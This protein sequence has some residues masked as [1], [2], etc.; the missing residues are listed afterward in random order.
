GLV[1]RD[2][3]VP[4]RGGADE[5]ALHRVAHQ[6]GPLPPVVRVVVEIRLV[7][8]QESAVAQVAQDG[9]VCVLEPG[10]RD[11]TGLIGEGAVRR[12]QI[13]QRKSLLL[14]YVVVIRAEGGRNV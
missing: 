9:F 10:T 7:P 5:P 3:S 4:D 14:P 2:E 6:R 12:D 8:E 13:Q 11:E 1:Q